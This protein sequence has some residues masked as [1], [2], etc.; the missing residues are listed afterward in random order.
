M[1]MPSDDAAPVE[2]RPLASRSTAWA[3][4]AS[5]FLVRRGASPNGISVAGLAFGCCAGAAFAATR[6]LPGAER[7]LFLAAA[8]AIQLRLLCNLL[9]G[10]VAV[11]GGRRSPVGELYNEAPDRIS[12]A[13]TFVGAGY[14]AGA[15]PEWGWA[16]ACVAVW[17]AY[18]RALAKTAGAPNDFCGPMAKQHRMALMTA[19]AAYLALGPAAWRPNFSPIDAALAVVVVLGLLTSLRRLVHAARSLRSRAA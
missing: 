16:A 7:W 8:V 3:R 4:A 19:V 9:D 14:A 18:V 1:T 12:D 13:A 10:M 2:R 6:C 5:A 11:E 17:V 15:T